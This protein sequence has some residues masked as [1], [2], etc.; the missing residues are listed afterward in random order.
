MNIFPK[1]GL[2]V[3]A[4]F[5]VSFASLGQEQAKHDTFDI[6]RSS[7]QFPHQ[8]E[9]WGF[10]VSAGLLLVK[11]PY[12]LMEN[13]Y[14]GP[15]ANFHMTFG[16]PWKFSLEG[17]ISTVIVSNQ[18]ALGPRLSFNYKNFGVKLG[19]DLAFSYGQL[20]QFGFDNKSKVW[21]HYPNISLGYKLKKM[22]FTA[23]GELV[24]LASLSQTTGENEISH[25]KN[26]F[27]GYTAAIYIEQRLWKNH[28]FIIG[29]KD[30]YEKFYWPT[31][32]LFSTFNRYYH[33]PEL[34]F[35]WIL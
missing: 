21:I 30:S 3:I 26:F 16:L 17:D 12:D 1:K 11:P 18:F 31:W 5:L 34:S 8:P 2:V 4:C 25:T 33:I 10:Q 9:K 27:N 22:A 29:F 14:E 6:T 15:L 23:K 20:H 13:A 32:M 28:V 35:I 7:M 19:W 24:T